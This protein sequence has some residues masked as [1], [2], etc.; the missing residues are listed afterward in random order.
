MHRCLQEYRLH[1]TT[2]YL[3][4][5]AP[6]SVFQIRNSLHK[7]P[8]QLTTMNPITVFCA[9]LDL[10]YAGVTSPRSVLV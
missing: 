4:V 8:H 2:L 9:A 6:S 7:K 5:S 3:P 10:E 1:S